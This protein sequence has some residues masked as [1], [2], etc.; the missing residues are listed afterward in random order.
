METGKKKLANRIKTLA[1]AFILF[2]VLVKGS[3]YFID[4]HLCGELDKEL[5]QMV[6]KAEGAYGEFFNL[7]HIPCENN[8]FEVYAKGTAFDTSLIDSLHLLLY[9]KETR[10]GWVTL[11]VYDKDGRYLFTHSNTNK[12]YKQKGD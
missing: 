8:Y 1:I 11:I 4:N 10:R 3:L 9:E 5:Q 6:K 12:I 7:S 2:I